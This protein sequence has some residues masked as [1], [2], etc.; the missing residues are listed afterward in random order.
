M[1]GNNLLMPEDKYMRNGNY[2]R[3]TEFMMAGRGIPGLH[4]GERVVLG[5]NYQIIRIDGPAE[6][7]LKG[8]PQPRGR[9]YRSEQ[10]CQQ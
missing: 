8:Q 7:E 1:T 9:D 5:P 10:S 2:L 6:P 4:D 3:E